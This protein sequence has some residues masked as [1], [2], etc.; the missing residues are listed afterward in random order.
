M[1]TIIDILRK[2]NQELFH[3]SMI[4]WLLDPRAEHG[5]G[6]VF[7]EQFA[8]KL[9]DKGRPELLEIVKTALPDSVRT[10][11]TSY[12]SRYDIV[13][14]IG[15]ILIVIE[16]KTKSL[17]EWPQ[18]RKYEATNPLLVALGLCDVSFSADV[19][20]KYPLL[21]YRDVLGILNN[22]PKQNNDFGVLIDH[23]RLF[24]ERE[25]SILEFIVDCYAHGN[26]NC[27]TRISELVKTA[28]YT[29][30]DRRFLNLYFLEKF[31]EHLSNSPLWQ[32]A[33]WSTNKNMQSGVWLANYDAK[34]PNSYYVNPSIKRFC[35]EKSAGLWFH[36][37]LW[38]GVFAVGLDDTVGMLQLR[39]G[40]KSDKKEFIKEFQGLYKPAEGEYYPSRMR[41]AGSF[42]LVGR[43]L[44]KKELVFIQLEKQ[45]IC[46]AERFG[47]FRV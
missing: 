23:Y 29:D 11:A 38:N 18:F 14:S 34:L 7:L 19:A 4:A 1:R 27:H 41:D 26:L 36:I 35:Q 39:C 32:E 3:S 16:N 2:G 5:L 21:T 47:S 12:K 17:G 28:S 24:L 25:L 40:T 43:N 8:D 20:S 42:Y 37:E 44:S 45:M 6:K 31:R 22:L 10:E 33:R 46:F 9:V 15:Q 30:N 13:I